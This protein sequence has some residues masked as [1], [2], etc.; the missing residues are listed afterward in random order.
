MRALARRT[1]DA[2][3]GVPLFRNAY[4]LAANTAITSALGFA[5]WIAAARLY[6]PVVVGAGSAAVSLMMVS[7][8]V[9][10]LN[11]MQ[12]LARVLPAL[13]RR[14]RG[15]V[16]ASYAVT[17]LLAL[18]VVG[19]L[20][21]VVRLTGVHIGALPTDEPGALMWFAGAVVA[22]TVFSLQDGVLTGL[23]R[24]AWLPV[25]N[26]G[27]GVLKLVLLVA[28]AG[29]LPGHGI[30]AAWTLPLVVFIVPINVLVYRRLLRPASVD[31]ADHDADSVSAG[32]ADRHDDPA[33][34]GPADRDADSASSDPADRDADPAFA[35][36]AIAG[37]VA[38]DYVGSLFALASTMLLPPIV[39]ALLGA[40]ANAHFYVA[41]TVVFA[42]ETVA[43]NFATSLTVEGAID[44]SALAG[45]SGAIVRRIGLLFAVV[46]PVLLLIAPFVLA[47]YG[48]TYAQESTTVLR[49]LALGVVGRAVI[50][51][52]VAIARVQ[53]RVR[54]IITIEAA[55]GLLILGGTPLGIALLGLPGVAV[56]YA[57]AH[58]VVAAALTPSLVR[59]V[60]RGD[61]DHQLS[62]APT[63]P[64]VL[65]MSIVTDRNAG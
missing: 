42:L 52:S 40:R 56:A 37:F 21:A 3:G 16:T 30:F 18:L 7:S 54:R 29:L 60:R 51:P 23:R 35:A 2:H 32:P 9:A 27:F 38:G 26:A 5:F 6:A 36:R 15:L 65:A 20:V 43:L 57:V 24:A 33:S 61:A 58:V 64:R 48:P 1:R 63:P 49:V 14:R 4:A 11:L 39:L 22:W 46:V 50:A 47:I 28:F 53:R 19:L 45:M 12:G 55:L 34:A 10:Q 31:P 62:P 13:G 8:T 25:E 44:G 41:W 17:A 59:F